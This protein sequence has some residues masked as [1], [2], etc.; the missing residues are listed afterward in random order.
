MNTVQ[1]L[2]RLTKDPE[3]ETVKI[4]KEKKSV[5]NF[6]IAVDRGFGEDAKTDFIE[7]VAWEKRA[8]ILDEYFKKG[9]RIAVTGSLQV[10]QWKDDEGNNRSRTRVLVSSIDFC[11]SSKTK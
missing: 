5:C 10:D 3:A 7:C 6:T 4:G 2:G 8:E 1:L 9:Q 11:E